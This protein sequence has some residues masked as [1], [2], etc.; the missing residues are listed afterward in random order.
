MKRSGDKKS[1]LS[2]LIVDSA[3]SAPS[4]RESTFS[5]YDWIA[6]D[7][8]IGSESVVSFFTAC[9]SQDQPSKALHLVDC[10]LPQGPSSDY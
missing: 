1:G 3:A 9:E 4:D 7:I 2:I 8:H 5:T 6:P 10:Y